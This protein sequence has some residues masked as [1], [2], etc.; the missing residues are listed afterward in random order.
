M[1]KFTVFSEDELLTTLKE[2]CDWKIYNDNLE[3]NFKF[4]D[5]RSAIA[6][7]NMLAMECE[8]RNHH[9]VLKN[10]YK[11]VEISL[12]THAADN[13]ITDLD[14]NMARYISQIVGKFIS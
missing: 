6:F 10:N 9:P 7:I 5:F 13:K 11:H 1:D 3:A 12:C 14:V 2:L 8:K 4:P